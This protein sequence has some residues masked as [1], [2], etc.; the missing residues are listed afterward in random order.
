MKLEHLKK[1]GRIKHIPDGWR[2][3]TI[4]KA[5]IVRN[6][7]RKPISVDE[8]AKMQGKYPYYGPT[9]LLDYIDEYLVEGEF[10]LIGE[11]G[12]HFLKPQEKRQ[13]LLLDGK[14]NVN[15]HAHIIQGTEQ[16]LA[17]WFYLYFH[18]RDITNLLSRQGANRYKLNKETLK[19]IPILLPGIE[20]QRNIFLINSEWNLA[21][22]KIVELIEVKQKHFDSLSRSLLGG[23]RRLSDFSGDWKKI[24]FED[25]F[26]QYKCVNQSNGDYEVLSV[27]KKGIVS[28]RDYFNKDVASVDRSK[29][30]V[31]ERGVLV[32]SGLNFWM[33]AIDFQTIR[34]VGIVSPAYKTFKL[35]SSNYN[36]DYF[37]FFVRSKYMT[38][39][40]VESSIQGASIVRR[41]LDMDAL[42]NAIIHIPCIKEQNKIVDLLMLAEKELEILNALASLYKDQKLGLMQKL[43]SGEWSIHANKEVA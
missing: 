23:I 41:N 35:R 15:N 25:V 26:E 9:G 36:S 10:A 24:K 5:C 32:M 2:L 16:C 27:T 30:R 22:E 3:T 18:H 7:L 28:Q 21:I 39:I 43:L 4:G 19:K 42:N 20:E 31:V 12:D 34:D 40:L 6:D 11:D 14:F 37:R 29:Y 17:K 1:L 33:G 13:T 8:R 38:R